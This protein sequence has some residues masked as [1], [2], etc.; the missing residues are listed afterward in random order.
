MQKTCT[1]AEKQEFLQILADP[2][3]EEQLRQI[4]EAYDQL[5]ETG[6]TLNPETTVAV[7]EAIRK[8]ASTQPALVVPVK[9]RYWWAVAAALVIILAAV[10]INSWLLPSVP[11]PTAV[12]TKDSSKTVINPGSQGAVLI[13]DNGMSISLD[14][15]QNGL[16]TT[17]P[18][19]T[20]LLKNGEILYNAGADSNKLNGTAGMPVTYNKMVT[21]RGRQFQLTL[22]DGTKVWLNAASSLRYPTMFTGS[23]RRVEITGEAYFEVAHDATKPFIVQIQDKADIQV[24]GTH[25]N[26]NAYADE[27]VLRT[28]LLEGK[29]KITP[30]AGTGKSVTLS[31]DEECVL[32]GI[33][34][35]VKKV[36]VET[37]VAW[38][39][40]RFNF[41]SADLDMV[42]RQLARWYDVEIRYNGKSNSRF[43]GSMYRS[44]DFYELLQLIGY[45]SNVSVKVEQKIIT[46]TPK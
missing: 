12:V 15:L 24:L 7:W 27:P 21:P 29:V 37:A 4:S 18:G 5:P 41:K 43:S 10:A 28:T 8:G 17:Q 11:G 20:V 2:S 6:L 13:L 22:P 38:I 9:K 36:E 1:P 46:V 14:S 35:E 42:F 39:N 44:K 25:F 32:D 40:G 33:H 3:Y 16:V 34:T 23:D 30:K 26:V 45:T 31:P 19:A